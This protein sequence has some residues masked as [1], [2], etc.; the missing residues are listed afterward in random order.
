MSLKRTRRTI[1]GLGW[2]HATADAKRDSAGRPVLCPCLQTGFRNKVL[3]GFALLPA[4]FC[5]IASRSVEG[6]ALQQDGAAP[7]PLSEQ[8]SGASSLV[9]SPSNPEVSEGTTLAVTDLALFKSDGVSNVDQLP[10]T[11][12]YTIQVVNNGPDDVAGATVSDVFPE[13]FQEVR[14]TC[15]ATDGPSSSV[16]G[17]PVSSCAAGLMSGDIVDVVNIS[18]GGT[19]TYLATGSVG[20]DT[21]LFVLTNVA[22]VTPPAQAVDPDTGNNG[23]VDRTVLRP[24]LVDSFQDLADASVGDGVCGADTT[25]GPSVCT[26]RAAIQEAN[27]LSEPVTIV[28]GSGTY[29]LTLLD[30][31][32][33]AEAG[34]LDV[35]MGKVDIEGQ[36]ADQTFIEW[37]PSPV[38]VTPLQQPPPERVFEIGLGT[39]VTISGVTIRNGIA[40]APEEGGG[41]KN[42]GVLTLVGCSL[43]DNLAGLGGAVAN[44]GV[45]SIERSTI[46]ENSA[47]ADNSL[48]GFGG[49]VWNIGI[50]KQ[51]ASPGFLAIGNSTL[52]GNTAV[53]G[54]AIWNLNGMVDLTQVTVARN[55]AGAQGSAIFSFSDESRLS[56][57]H[58]IVAENAPLN[59][60]GPALVTSDGSSLE[61]ADSCGLA[62]GDLVNTPAAIGDLGNNDG[63]DGVT[64]THALQPGSGAID[65]GDSIICPTP[66]DQRGAPRSVDGD[67]DG[68]GACDIGAYEAPP[69]QSV[70]LVLTVPSALETDPQ[71]AAYRM[72]GSPFSNTPPARDLLVPALGSL[73]AGSRWRLLRYDVDD[74]IYRELSRDDLDDPFFE[75]SPV[76]RFIGTQRSGNPGFWLISRD[77]AEIAITGTPRNASGPPFRIEL[78]PSV[79]WQQVTSPLN[80]DLDWEGC[81]APRL[82]AE[83]ETPDISICAYAPEGGQ[84]PHTFPPGNRPDYQFST[85]MEAGTGYWFYL[86]QTH[87]TGSDGDPTISIPPV[88]ARAPEMPLTARRGPLPVSPLRPGSAG[89]WRLRLSVRAGGLFDSQNYLG[90]DVAAQDERD[91]LDFREPPQW[92]GLSLYFPRPQWSPKAP[93]FASDIR[94]HLP[95]RVMWRDSGQTEESRVD[96]RVWTFE[97]SSTQ[98]DEKV[99]LRWE[100]LGALSNRL[101]LR[102]VDSDRWIDLSEDVYRYRNGPSGI[103]RFEVVKLR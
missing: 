100:V 102:D 22:T 73:P 91:R 53:Q 57:T 60:S 39:T 95:S 3:L 34:D 71:I 44:R 98:P 69:F 46:W 92:H 19:L 18:V 78:S 20:A 26:L 14:W 49:G 36:G 86:S 54:A 85:T 28:L 23:A 67:G 61:D 83:T 16:R 41:I 101:L 72:I 31:S 103:R 66:E 50:L 81:V 77:E 96:D 76:P 43:T 80:F 87:L 33:G 12:T 63:V 89:G 35:I 90:E 75:F 68:A 1:S 52:S 30:Q 59:C 8:K 64:L 15:A 45:L 94:E 6:R 11:L 5:L 4:L 10:V 62:D 51:I 65:G 48:G 58:T 99:E 74:L 56:L 42:L 2:R 7:A 38:S 9:A 17:A 82:A 88:C 27:T 97:V 13:G 21:D 84:N 55:L 79:G 37:P 29:R 32:A 40:V 70:P 25:Q 47:I 24:F 93:R